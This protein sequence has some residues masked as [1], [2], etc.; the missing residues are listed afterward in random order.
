MRVRLPIIILILLCI[1][2]GGTSFAFWMYTNL[3]EGYSIENNRVTVG[4]AKDATTTVDFS[5]L[6]SANYKLVP[7]GRAQDAEPGA[8][9]FVLLSY[10][11]SWTNDEDSAII[12]EGT[13]FDLIVQIDNVTP[14][15][16]LLASLLNIS[17]QVGGSEPIGLTG[18]SVLDNLQGTI[19][20]NGDAVMVYVLVTLTNPESISDYDQIVGEIIIFDVIFTVSEPS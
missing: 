2:V 15:N 13:S 10:E 8:V 18:E 20:I 11:I 5:Y 6:S 9:E 12:P 16:Q 3:N 14:N 4:T 17:Y 7:F 1:L 19:V